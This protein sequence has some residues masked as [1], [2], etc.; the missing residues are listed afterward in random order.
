MKNNTNYPFYYYLLIIVFIIIS[1]VFWFLFLNRSI[2]ITSNYLTENDFKNDE[3]LQVIHPINPD[4]LIIDSVNNRRIV[5][6]IVN[7]ALK[8]NEKTIFQFAE[9]LKKVYEDPSFEIVYIDSVINRLQVKL[10]ELEREKFK[11]EV[12]SNLPKDSLLVWDEMM[13]QMNNNYTEKFKIVSNE[14]WF[15]KYIN[16]QN[17]WNSTLGNP[18]TVI[19][20]VDNGFDLNHET[21]LGKSIKPYNTSTKNS[22]VSPSLINHGTHVASIAI[23]NSNT[24]N[25]VCPECNYMPIKVEDNNGLIS[26]SYVIDA[27]LYAIKNKASIINLS[28]GTELPLEKSDISLDEQKKIINTQTKDLEEF[29]NQLFLY[30]EERNV[31]SVIAAGNNKQ[32]TGLDPFQRSDKT[33]KVSTVSRNGKL[34]SFS[35]FGNYNTIYVPGEQIYGAKPNNLYE[36]LD[37][38]SMSAPII[39]GFIGL[40]KSKYPNYKFDD[41]M[42][43]LKSNTVEMNKIKLLN[44]KSI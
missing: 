29:W 25:G 36:Y 3:S 26:M 12:K 4:E 16:V 23:G 10:P 27:I 22:D 18:K 6:N 13:F 8:N 1:T 11:L 9:D 31:I 39:S 32:L 19:A 14:N 43:V 34:A 38:T 28:L 20:I 30:G 35:N 41:V 24:Y 37:G 2:A 17:A 15:L 21:L 7:I 5:S 42:N 40:I 44:I 33:I